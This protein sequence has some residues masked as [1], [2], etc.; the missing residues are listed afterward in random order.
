MK[1]KIEPELQLVDLP[2][3]DKQFPVIELF[4][5][6]IQGEGPLAGARSHFIRFGGCAYRCHWCDSMH[7]V[8]PKEIKKNALMLYPSQIYLVL[9]KLKP[10]AQ[11]CTLTGGD[12]VMWDLQG[13]MEVHNWH[14]NQ[15]SDCISGFA[16]E[17]QGAI[18]REWLRALSVVILTVSPK[19]PSSG[20]KPDFNVISEYAKDCAYGHNLNLKVVVFNDEDYDF[21]RMVHKKYPSVPFYL[22]VGTSTPPVTAEDITKLEVL[23][24]Y[25]W[26]VEKT[27][28]DRIMKDAR[29]LPQLHYLIWGNELG[30]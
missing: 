10:M 2:G 28:A 27:L 1:T 30:R 4:G 22:S 18:Y 14:I 21:A 25:K 8:D 3:A 23:D 29:V 20:E 26:L 5:P 13:L 12:P 15:D 9:Q 19:P 6:T 11:Y 7:A 16:V 24:R 17:T